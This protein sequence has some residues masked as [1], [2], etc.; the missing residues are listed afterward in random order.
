ML[1]YKDRMIFHRCLFAVIFRKSGRNPGIYKLKGMF[2]NSFEPFGGD[3]ISVFLGQM[4]LGPE[5]GFF[6]EASFLG[7]LEPA[8]G[9]VCTDYA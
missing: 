7:M 1:C 6:R 2:L 9:I 5:L 8:N 3:V 4:E